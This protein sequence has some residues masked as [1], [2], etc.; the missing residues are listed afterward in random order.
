MSEGSPVSGAS[1][2]DTATELIDFD[3]LEEGQ[4]GHTV[5]ESWSEKTR[6]WS[7][8]IL[9]AAI[10]RVLSLDELIGWAARLDLVN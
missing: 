5:G 3:N 6:Y 2:E 7:E 4:P 10:P 1:R 8:A 9:T